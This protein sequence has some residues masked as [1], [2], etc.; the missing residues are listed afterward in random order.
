MSNENWWERWSKE[1]I[2]KEMERLQRANER[3]ER[4]LVEII[5]HDLCPNNG[6][7]EFDTRRVWCAHCIALGAMKVDR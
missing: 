4:A 1:D 5:Q 3:Y 6:Y 7:N 2:A